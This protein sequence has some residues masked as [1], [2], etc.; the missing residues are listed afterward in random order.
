MI[1]ANWNYD[2]LVS[3]DFTDSHKRAVTVRLSVPR[4][5]VGANDNWECFFQLVGI[6]SNEVMSATGRDAWQAMSVAAAGIRKYASPFNLKSTVDGASLEMIMP[7]PLPT[8]YGPD[9]YSFVSSW[10][11]FQMHRE[12]RRLDARR[13]SARG[14]R[15]A[16]E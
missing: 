6:G 14:R 7:R 4:I 9:F 16:A 3:L 5:Q 15:R 2:N 12:Q 10:V 1:D 8:M 13:R 11:D